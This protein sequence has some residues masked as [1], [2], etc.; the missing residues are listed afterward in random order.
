MFKIRYKVH[1]SA[2]KDNKLIFREISEYVELRTIQG[3]K[4]RLPQYGILPNQK[5]NTSWYIPRL[6]SKKIP[7]PTDIDRVNIY[8]RYILD[9]DGYS[10]R[11]DDP[12]GFKTRTS[13]VMKNFE[14]DAKFIELR[15]NS[16]VPVFKKMKK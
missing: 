6:K 9:V 13:L 14:R 8:I 5:W 15:E 10:T 2:S 4:N 1:F 3:N 11:Y 7:K 12:N 16:V